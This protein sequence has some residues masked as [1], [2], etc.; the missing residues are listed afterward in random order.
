MASLSALVHPPSCIFVLGNHTISTR[1][2]QIKRKAKPAY[3]ELRTIDFDLSRRIA[4]FCRKINGEALVQLD[5]KAKAAAAAAEDGGGKVGATCSTGSIGTSS[6]A[7]VLDEEVGSTR[8]KN[9]IRPDLPSDTVQ[10]REV[11]TAA[12]VQESTRLA[13]A[14]LEKA[15]QQVQWSQRVETGKEVGRT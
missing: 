7:E 3:L 5:E 2:T 9:V 6:L 4:S 11:A 10:D 1:K 15:E 14:L 12:S 13:D 8:N